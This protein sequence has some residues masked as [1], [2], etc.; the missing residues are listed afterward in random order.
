MNS[1]TYNGLCGL[2]E[3]SGAA[4]L[5]KLPGPSEAAELGEL[6]GPGRLS[7]QAGQQGRV[8]CLSCLTQV[9]QPSCDISWENLL[10]TRGGQR[11]SRENISSS[12]Q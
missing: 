10:H 9:Q 4:E 11:M 7:G 5:G 6:P 12:E 2:T 3:L 1:L 8:H